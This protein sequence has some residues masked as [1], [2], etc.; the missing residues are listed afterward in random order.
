M[1][2]GEGGDGDEDRDGDKKAIPIDILDNSILQSQPEVSNNDE[3]SHDDIGLPRQQSLNLSQFSQMTQISLPYTQ[4][5]SQSTMTAFDMINCAAQEIAKRD[6]EDVPFHAYGVA[7]TAV[8]GTHKSSAGKRQS[9]T[10]DVGVGGGNGDRDDVW[11]TAHDRD[12]TTKLFTY[13]LQIKHEEYGPNQAT[14]IFEKSNDIEEE[15]AAVIIPKEE[16]KEEESNHKIGIKK[17]T[18]EEIATIWNR[19]DG[20]IIPPPR[21]NPSILTK[22]QPVNVLCGGTT[23]YSSCLAMKGIIMPTAYPHPMQESNNRNTPKKYCQ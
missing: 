2:S 13:P 8:E 9:R 6:G 4:S 23:L 11:E 15:R 17:V 5:Q 1:E 18:D 19:E 22:Q 20:S 12:T 16:E 14:S 10:G 3:D 7:S 21:L